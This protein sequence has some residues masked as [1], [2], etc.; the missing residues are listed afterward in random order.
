M[1]D[2]VVTDGFDSGIAE[3]N[4]AITFGGRVAVI[5]GFYVG[6]QHSAHDRQFAD[7]LGGKAGCFFSLGIGAG[8]TSS[9]YTGSKT[10]SGKDLLGKQIK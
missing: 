9:F 5:G 1:R 6:S 7:K 8:I 4:F 3:N 10:Q 2:A